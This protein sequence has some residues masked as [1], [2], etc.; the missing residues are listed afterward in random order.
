MKKKNIFVD[1]VKAIDSLGHPVLVG[2]NDKVKYNGKYYTIN[3]PEAKNQ[4]VDWLYRPSYTFKA[5]AAYNL[6]KHHSIFANIGWLNRAIRYNN[7]I[8]VNN[9]S[10]VAT[11]P[12]SLVDNAKDETIKAVELGYGFKS[13][14]FSANINGYYTIWENRPLDVLPYTTDPTDGQRIY[15]NVNGLSAL[16]KG[17]ELDFK[18]SPIKTL[19]VDG[20][21]SLGDWRWTS[22]GIAYIPGNNTV[23]PTPFDPSGT[24]VGN[25]AQTQYGLG[26]RYEIVRG[27]YVRLRT[28]YFGNNYSNF[29]PED[30]KGQNAQREAWRIPDYSLVDF[31]AGYTCYIQKMKT[32]FKFSVLNML[33][34]VYVTDATNN[35]NGTSFDAASANVFFVKSPNAQFVGAARRCVR[36]SAVVFRPL[37]GDR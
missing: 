10:S 16:H 8:Q 12:V 20:I 34:E 19:T 18:Y 5:G 22:P 9:S 25:V 13:K 24:H 7:L 2:Y 4:G 27:L 35:F 31:H 15:Y 30:L 14:V 21:L 32:T 37:K 33:N 1:G 36:F 17:I 28:T 29:K 11:V 26:L 3:S 6:N 23:T